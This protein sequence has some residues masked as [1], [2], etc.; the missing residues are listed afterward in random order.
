MNLTAGTF[1]KYADFPVCLI[2]ILGLTCISSSL[3]VEY[4]LAPKWICLFAWILFVVLLNCVQTLVSPGRLRIFGNMATMIVAFVAVAGFMSVYGLV[5]NKGLIPSVGRFRIT[6]SFDNPAG[7]ASA[8]VFMMPFILYGMIAANKILR[9]ASQIVFFV[10]FLAIALSGSR[11]GMLSVLIILIFGGHKFITKRSVAKWGL[12]I[13]WVLLLAAYMYTKMDSA[14]GRLLI[15]NVTFDM[16]R[17]NWLWGMGRGGFAAEYMNCQAA[18]LADNPN[19]KWMMLADNIQ[20]PFNELLYLWVSFG[21]FPVLALCVLGVCVLKRYFAD[22]CPE[23]LVA[24]L[25]F[26]SVVVFAM[27]SYPFKYP[28][29][30]FV[31]AYSIAILLHDAPFVQRLSEL[32]AHVKRMVALIIFA[33]TI[34]FS[35]EYNSRIRSELQWAEIVASR[36]YGEEQLQQYEALYAKKNTDRFFLYNYA[37]A[38]YHTENYEKARDVAEKCEVLWADYDLQL[39]L[40]LIAEKQNDFG[41]A[42]E[43]FDMASAMCP[44]RFRPLHLKMNLCETL[45]DIENAMKIAEE[46]MCKKIKVPSVEVSQIVN[47]ATGFYEQNHAE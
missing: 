9:G 31:V 38:L 14:S 36:Q 10:M 7:F 41:R 35:Y 3:F 1:K 25:S 43:C 30:W 19:E 28:F 45:G 32:N 18:F 29:T 46:I 37:Y 8:L 21:I 6:G 2:I 15:W 5:Q 39:L 42:M 26:L 34:W 22:R 33:V 27:F 47:H 11:A 40:G 16:I 4:T 44:N 12:I 23:K 24:L 13:A 17:D 20:H